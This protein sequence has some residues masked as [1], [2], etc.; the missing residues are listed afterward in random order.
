MW[1]TEP[2]ARTPKLRSVRRYNT[3]RRAVPD[4]P[5]RGA[6]AATRV[7]LALDAAQQT[8]RAQRIARQRPRPPR[9]QRERDVAARAPRESTM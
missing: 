8:R 6:V 4:R 1:P 9:Q 7:D 5:T 2:P 3:A